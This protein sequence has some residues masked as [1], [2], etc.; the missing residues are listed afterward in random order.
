M[1]SWNLFLHMTK[2]E[3]ACLVHLAQISFQKPENKLIQKSLYTKV[4]CEMFID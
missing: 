3:A 2:I 4:Y 1:A